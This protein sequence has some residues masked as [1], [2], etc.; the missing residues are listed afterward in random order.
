[1]GID[2]D[3][4]RSSV[5]GALNGSDKILKVLAPKDLELHLAGTNFSNFMLGE[6]V[7][8]KE[9]VFMAEDGDAGDNTVMELPLKTLTGGEEVRVHTSILENVVCSS[10]PNK[11]RG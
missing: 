7:E 11:V 4:D 1:M 5:G 10:P 9:L 6:V 3:G 2:A 8:G